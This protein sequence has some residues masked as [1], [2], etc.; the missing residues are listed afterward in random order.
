MAEASQQFI[1]T[2]LGEET[3]ANSGERV[4]TLGDSSGYAISFATMFAQGT[5]L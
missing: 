5:T 2:I 1:T 4:S 3:G